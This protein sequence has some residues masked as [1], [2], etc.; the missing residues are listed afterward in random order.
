MARK[1]PANSKRI[2]IALPSDLTN[3]EFR[4]IVEIAQRKRH[5]DRPPWIVGYVRVSK[6]DYTHDDKGRRIRE[7][8]SPDEQTDAIN[9]LREKVREKNPDL[10]MG[11]LY[12][13]IGVSAIKKQLDNRPGGLKML[14]ELQPGDHVVFKKVDRPFRRVVDLARWIDEWDKKGITFHFCDFQGMEIDTSSP[15][16]RFFILFCGVVA[17]WEGMVITQRNRDIARYRRKRMP[18]A[19]KLASGARGVIGYKIRGPKGRRYLVEDPQQ[20]DW[21]AFIRLL[22]DRLRLTF[23]E[24]AEVLTGRAAQMRALKWRARV[25]RRQTVHDWYERAVELGI[26]PRDAESVTAKQPEGD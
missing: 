16:G 4:Q 21:L 7:G 13:D 25:W 19:R 1:R 3:E 9:R 23:D 24:I 22:R 17:E 5:T 14:G 8:L 15:M 20:R 10:E 2:P 26:E 6:M 11:P 18:E 12:E